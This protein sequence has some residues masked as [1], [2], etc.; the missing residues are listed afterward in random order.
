M[1]AM[2]SAYLAKALSNEFNRRG[3]GSVR[4]RPQRDQVAAARRSESRRAVG[5][6]RGL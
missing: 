4:Y 1:N 6:R 5:S 2:M 3:A